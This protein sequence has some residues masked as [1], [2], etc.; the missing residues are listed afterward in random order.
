M[1]FNSISIRTIVLVCGVVLSLSNGCNRGNSPTENVG[2][3]SQLHE[4][5]VLDLPEMLYD[6]TRPDSPPKVNVLVLVDSSAS[7]VGFRPVLPSLLQGVEQGLSYSRDLYFNVTSKE[8]CFFNQ[9]QGIYG[10]KPQ[11][12]AVQVGSASGYTNL[13][14]AVEE[15][16]KADIAV[17]FTDGVPAGA[18]ASTDCVG[19]GVDAACVAAALSRAVQGSPGTGKGKMRGVWILPFVTP[20]DGLYYAE[21]PIP[22]NEFDSDKAEKNVSQSI[23][24]NTRIQTPRRSGDGTLVFDYTG[25]RYLLAIVIGEIEPSR[26]FIQEFSSR[27]LFSRIIRIEQTNTF[28]G[29]VGLL[30]PIEVFPGTIPPQSYGSCARKLQGGRLVG[31]LINCQKIGINDFRLSCGAQSYYAEFKFS[32]TPSPDALRMKFLAPLSVSKA[33]GAMLRG[34]RVST[35]IQSASTSDISIMAG[36]QCNGNKLVDCDGNE[37]QSNLVSSANFDEAAKQLAGS[38]SRIAQF[39]N[40][41]STRTPATEPHKVY[42]LS[43]LLQNFYRR[44]LPQAELPFATLKLCQG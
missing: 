35:T 32:G 27:S 33:S 6:H 21:Q 9:R 14:R 19:S 8:T 26:A 42:G 30:P 37:S 25:P 12:D 17:I 43:D 41:F 31:D 23:N 34:A 24:V 20:Y 36:I 5:E 22:P 13:D 10:C 40:G 11:I 1:S 2:T 15:A 16:Q 44:S 39:I 7:M 18:G 28:Q 38:N 29:G 3:T 4:P